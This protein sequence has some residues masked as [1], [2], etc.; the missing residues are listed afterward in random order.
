M[1]ISGPRDVLLFAARVSR[2]S[3]DPGYLDS[4]VRLF[5]K[6]N[7]IAPLVSSSE[8]KPPAPQDQG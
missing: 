2:A 5:A 4:L 8:P 3:E 1:K 6:L 7:Q